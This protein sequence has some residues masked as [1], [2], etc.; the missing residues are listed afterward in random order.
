MER[1]L[2]RPSLSPWHR[3]QHRVLYHYMRWATCLYLAISLED[4]RMLSLFR[5]QHRN[6]QH[7]NCPCC[8]LA[9]QRLITP[10]RLPSL[11]SWRDGMT[12]GERYIRATLPYIVG[13]SANQR[14]E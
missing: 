7:P 13:Y 2:V 5:R 14:G 10:R 3:L 4:L 6:L 8:R 11:T 1:H 9:R 12:V